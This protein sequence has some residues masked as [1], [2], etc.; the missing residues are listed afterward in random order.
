[1]TTTDLAPEQTAAGGFPAH[2]V[3]DIGLAAHGVTR[4]EWAEREMPVLRLIR[5]RF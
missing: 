1:M 5:A 3:T 2:D 4:I